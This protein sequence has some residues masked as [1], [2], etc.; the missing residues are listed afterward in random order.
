MWSRWVIAAWVSQSVPPQG[1]VAA[2]PQRVGVHLLW[3]LLPSLAPALTPP[4]QRPRLCATECAAPSVPR[5]RSSA[6]QQHAGE[7]P[8]WLQHPDWLVQRARRPACLLQLPRLWQHDQA[9]VQS[10]SA[11]GESMP[12]PEAAA[13]AAS[14]PTLLPWM[15]VQARRAEVGGLCRQPSPLWSRH[16]PRLGWMPQHWLAT[17]PLATGLG[18]SALRRRTRHAGHLPHQRPSR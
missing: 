17:P 15:L 3:L 18:P 16:Q 6:W 13:V 5:H 2:L 4:D 14:R 9:T 1:L 7:L 12:V 11:Q 8:W 10:Q